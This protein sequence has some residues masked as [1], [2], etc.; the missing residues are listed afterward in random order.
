MSSRSDVG[1]LENLADSLPSWIS[2]HLGEKSF[3][4]DEV[5]QLPSSPREDPLRVDTL[6]DSTSQDESSDHEEDTGMVE[7]SPLRKK[8]AL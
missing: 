8:P 5:N 7:H 2:K 3:M 1:D 4:I 6:E